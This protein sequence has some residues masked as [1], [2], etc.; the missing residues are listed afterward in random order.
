MKK[1]LVIIVILIMTVGYAQ[2]KRDSILP[3]Y[4]VPEYPEKFTAGTVAARMVEGLGFRFYWASDSLTEKDLAYKASPEGR[5]SKETIIHIYKI[6]DIIKNKDLPEYE[7]RHLLPYLKQFMGNQ[8]FPKIDL[9]CAFH[10]LPIHPDE[11]E[12]T[13]V[14]TPFG[15]Y[16]YVYMPFGLRNSASS[17][18]RFIDHIFRDCNFVCTFIDDILIKSKNEDE[19]KQHLEKVFKIL[20]D[21]GLKISLEKCEFFR[22]SLEFLGFFITK[23]GIK[24]TKKKIEAITSFPEPTES[25]SLRRF[26]GVIN[27]YRRLIPNFS[28]KVFNLTEMMKN[29]PKSKCFKLNEEAKDDFINIKNE[30]ASITALPHP[31]SS[32]TH[33]Q[34]VSDSSSY[35]I[36][37]ALHQIVDGNPIPIGFFSKKLTEP[38]RKYSTY[39][40]E[41]LAAF[42]SVLHFKPMIEGRNCTLFTDHR[43]LASAFKSQVPAKSDRQQRHLSIISEYISDIQYIRGDQNVVADCFSRVNA[44]KIDVTDLPALADLQKD[45]SEIVQYKDRLKSY[46][47]DSDKII[48]CNVDNI[49]P[50]PFVPLS[51]RDSVFNDLHSLCHPGIKASQKL[52]KS[53]YYWPDIDRD[54]KNKVKNCESCQQS[55]IQRHTKSGISHFSVP[56]TRLETVHIDIVGPLPVAKRHNEIYSSNCRYIVTFI[57]RATRWI[58]AAPIENITAQSVAV[59]F[60][61]TWISRLGVPLYLISDQGS[62]FESQLFSELSSLTGFHRLRTTGY[63]P[64][65][66]GMLERTHRTL[67]TALTARKSSWLDSLHVVLMGIRAIP[68]ESGYSPYT[69]LTGSDLLIPPIL[70][71]SSEIKEFSTEYVRKLVNEMSQIDFQSLSTGR[72]HVSSKSYIPSELNDCSHVWLRIDRIRRPLEAPYSGPFL[73]VKR[74]EKFFVIKSSRDKEITVSIDRLKPAFIKKTDEETKSD[75]SAINSNAAPPDEPSTSTENNSS[76]EASPE[77]TPKEVITRSGRRVK[78]RRDKNVHYY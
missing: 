30:L 20:F 68:N 8:Y 35:A 69:A 64:K 72:H 70:A 48:W 36:G 4:E 45:D 9:L 25:K 57:D 13:A 52:I 56:S 49:Q 3:F 2:E 66:N 31:A 40:R 18:Q 59:A 19:H 14:L 11:I 53:R 16:E 54:I 24:P 38:Q 32:A 34:I 42:Q 73:V 21:N 7:R 43:P 29:N 60:F 1:L 67:K 62:Q 10:Q 37:G 26:L 33:Y 63:N 23:D 5:T 39:D 6:M 78:F 71:N 61:E 75:D 44:I 15:L 77:N 58:E 50:R 46:E 41:L 28:S 12:K 47:L 65:C 74:S 76:N 55:K 27:F 51:A 17:F 22:D